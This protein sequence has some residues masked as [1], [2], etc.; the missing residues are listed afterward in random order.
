MTNSNSSHWPDG[1]S[2]LVQSFPRPDADSESTTLTPHRWPAVEAH[3]L[4]FI[5]DL[6]LTGWDDPAIVADSLGGA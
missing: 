2:G 4:S 1:Q 3:V 6:D 5:T